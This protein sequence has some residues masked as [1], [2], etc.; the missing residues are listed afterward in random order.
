MTLRVAPPL[1]S[2]DAEAHMMGGEFL[3]VAESSWLAVQ[4]SAWTC[5]ISH[6]PCMGG[7]V[8]KLA[9]RDMPTFRILEHP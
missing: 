1:W 5:C 7:R 3:S 2:S 9:F 4:L 6:A 8:T